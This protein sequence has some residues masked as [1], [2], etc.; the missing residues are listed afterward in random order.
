MPSPASLQQHQRS[1]VLNQIPLNSLNSVKGVRHS[2]LYTTPIIQIN[3][4]NPVSGSKSHRL[5]TRVFFKQNNSWDADSIDDSMDEETTLLLD[6]YAATFH[7][8]DTDQDGLLQ[9]IE[10]RTVLERVGGEASPL[11]WLTSEDIDHIFDQYDINQDQAIN[12][13]E[14][15]ALAHDNVFL[16]R[17]ISDYR[18][19]FRAID[20]NNDMF[21]GP[22][23][24]IS[25]LT[26]VGSPLS[27]Y[28]HI[29]R[30]MD[31]YD[32]DHNGRMDFGEFLRLC[33][34]EEALP[35]DD[36][37]KYAAAHNVSEIN[38]N[39]ATNTT[40]ATTATLLGSESTS[41][42]STTP[43]PAGG[44]AAYMAEQ[45][46]KKETLVMSIANEEAFNGV[47]ECNKEKLV[48][49]MGSL[50]WCRPCKR[51]APV[52][53]R[54][55]AAYPKAVFLHLN[56]ND[57]AE[58]KELFK[59]KLKMRA[60]PAFL[61]FRD[62]VVVDSCSGANPARFESHLR[63]ALK[64]EELPQRSLYQLIDLENDAAD[65]GDTTEMRSF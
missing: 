51:M 55:A 25:V 37:L 48:V 24:L 47:F 40:N 22:T 52:F 18:T 27:S 5:A 14:F 65:Q 23:E 35:L 34:Y 12:L 53:Q 62:V 60:T 20:K 54:M 2:S 6:K 30:L 45:R 57:S 56:G 38:T 9:R 19:A 64:E 4:A 44:A 10:L 63:R 36:I 59:N 11:H 16:T 8:A 46:A 58:T 3:S 26:A 28:E 21:L 33:R 39:V 61:F 31:K 1:H 29:V 32:T 43:K 13:S 17:A 15:M 50:S 42:D 49:V 7:E 41:S